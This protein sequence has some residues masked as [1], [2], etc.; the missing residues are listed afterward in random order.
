MPNRKYKFYEFFSG[1]GMARAGL[2]NRWECLFANDI[3]LKKAETYKINWGEKHL[4]IGGV[5]ELSADKI[6]GC[7]DLAW[8][9][10]PCQDLSQ[11]GGRGGLNQK[12]SGAFWPFWKLIKQLIENNRG[13]KIIVLENVCG[14]LTSNSGKDFS[15]IA[16]AFSRSNYKFGA[17]V[18][19]T[20]L[21]L[22]QSRPR[23]FFIAVD[24]RIEIPTSLISPSPNFNWHTKSMVSGL[25]N[26]TYA[27]RK[28]W[29][30]W[31]LPTP[32]ARKYDL[33]DLID[34]DLAEDSWHSRLETDCL[35]SLMNESHLL[36]VRSLASS[37]K[38]I[39]GTLFKRMRNGIQ[40]AEVRFDGIA[41]CLRTPS[42][43]SSKQI[44]LLVGN[45]EVR[46]RLISPSEGA[47]LM[48]LPED[49]SLPDNIN[50]SYKLI[51]D[52][53]A[54]PVVD[55]LSR[56]LLQSILSPTLLPHKNAA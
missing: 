7:A 5:K 8:A 15:S 22:P 52:G 18:I 39:A 34:K 53:V 3:D 35:L 37:K 28:K 16:D 43:G 13:P 42:G 31:D 38:L 46:S 29:V 23:L 17:V 4:T 36:K 40:R 50:D 51:G 30:W 19:D 12:R 45:G 41:G 54:V 21:F 56:H 49:Y 47:R 26:F 9:S 11:A 10:F 55:F 44:L 48:G 14:T 27:A 6:N 33:I 32:P 25:K 24:K 1:G 20:S 2:G